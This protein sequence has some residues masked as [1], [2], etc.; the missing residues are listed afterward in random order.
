MPLFAVG[1]DVRF[2]A[3]T[4]KRV[5]RMSAV[6]KP[7]LMRAPSV[8]ADRILSATTPAA[9]ADYRPDVDGLRAIA[10]LVVVLFHAFPMLLPGGFVG[11]DIFFVISGYLISKHIF[12]ELQTGRFQARDF[13][14]RRIKRIFPALILVLIATTAL[15]WVLLTPDEYK[16][17]GESIAGGAGFLANF[18]FWREA[19]Y[20][21]TAA[22][23]KPLLHLW[24]LGIEEQFYIVWPFFLA[25][26]WRRARHWIGHA[27]L[28]LIMASLAYS[29]WLV[30]RDVTADFY[31][32]LTRFWE[33][34]MGAALAFTVSRQRR[35]HEGAVSEW[36]PW[37]GLGLIVLA[38]CLLDSG[39]R[40]PGAWALLPAVGA[41]CL[42]HPSSRN[43][44]LNRAI[45]A[46]RPMVWIGL[47]SYPLYLWHWP[48]LSYASIVEAQTPSATARLVLVLVSVV[49]AWL[50]YRYV[51]RPVRG[52]VG[53]QAQRAAL[54][55]ALVM[56]LLFATGIAI[57]K[58]DGFKFRVMA[59]LNGDVTTL[60]IGEDRAAW[61]KECGIAEAQKLH[62][63]FC[64]SAG[65][66]APRFAVLG[67]SKAE[68]LYYGLARESA[69]LGS[70]L[71]GSVRPPNETAGSVESAVDIRNRLAFEAIVEDRSIRAVLFVVALRS[72][73][74]ASEIGF[75]E[76]DVSAATASWLKRYGRA[77]E[78]LEQAGKRVMF[79]MDH[80]TLPDPRNCISGGMT[81]SEFLN[82]FLR[83]K[84]NSRCTLRY[85]EHLAG[86]APYREFVN[87]LGRAH[88]RLVIYDP[89]R[90]LCDLERDQ[91][92]ITDG[93][94]FLY[95]Y[96]DHISDYA[97][98]KIARQ[99]L[100]LIEKLVQ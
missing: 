40:F 23:T 69:E 25:L 64:L 44:S 77:I 58:L 13:F 79:V 24:S 83:R 62:F 37:L 100:P 32:P 98:S 68:A 29:L 39:S 96:S 11:V 18:V 53:S 95:S 74:P 71:I 66:S 82:Q 91:C 26:C 81:S 88:P 10:V 45:L 78:R 63:R 46:S 76:S 28:V 65:P 12:G 30:Q 2:S 9:Q 84:P 27:M 73:F 4:T 50:T 54:L 6:R 87:T 92:T 42:I 51:E 35:E 93:A 60:R 99:L 57:R 67:D 85:T 90:W 80:P 48:L 47:V 15:G 5:R 16:R 22:E 17:M 70:V 19:G 36:L 89:S 43:S 59:N 20:F 14:V 38:L 31:S 3:I 8:L 7:L 75:I 94:R 34:G 86:T 56:I 97:S 72:T 61:R 49:L 33:L 52:R 21:D 55:L 1:G 41:V